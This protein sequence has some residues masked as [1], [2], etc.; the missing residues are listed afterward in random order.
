MGWTDPCIA[1]GKSHHPF[2][3]HR[4]IQ[5]SGSVGSQDGAIP[6]MSSGCVYVWSSWSWYP[7]V[8]LVSCLLQP[9]GRI[10]EYYPVNL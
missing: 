2:T 1:R 3:D 5:S 8:L 4:S 9:R 10:Q 7:C 6:K